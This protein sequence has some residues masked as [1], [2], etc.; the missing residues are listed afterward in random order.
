[1]KAILFT[2]ITCPKCP[3]FKEVVKKNINFEIEY[4]S[5]ENPDFI[6]KAKE[7]NI[8]SAPAIIIFDKKN[9]EIFRTS[10]ESELFDFLQKKMVKE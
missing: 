1:M 3:S 10:H 2:T 5:N 9:E 8:S 6:E 4:L 7:F